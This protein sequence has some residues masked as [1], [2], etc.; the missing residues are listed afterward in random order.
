MN[1]ERRAYVRSKF[2]TT[3][4]INPLDVLALLDA[5]DE[6]DRLAV[7]LAE[8]EARCTAAAECVERHVEAH[9]AEVAEL[10]AQIAERDRLRSAGIETITAPAGAEER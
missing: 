10:T 3:R 8:A 1:A 5:A 6:R 9:D 7:Q 4:E 2:Y